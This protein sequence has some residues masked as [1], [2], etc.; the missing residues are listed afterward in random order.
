MA[1]AT[2]CIAPK[3]AQAA[4]D[5]PEKFALLVGISE[6]PETSEFE[7]LSGPKNDV[8][9]VRNMLIETFGFVDD[10]SHVLV[11]QDSAATVEAIKAAF[12][13]HLID[14]AR[15]HPDGS[16]VFYFSGHGIQL[17]DLESDEGDRLD[18][19]LVA[20]DSVLPG[21]S[22]L[23]DDEI[24]SLLRDL[25]ELTSSLGN[26]T[27]IVDSCYSGNISRGNGLRRSRSLP[28]SEDDGAA[29]TSTTPT[30][31]NL[32][33][34]LL[35]YDTK[36]SVLSAALPHEE[37]VEDVIPGEIEGKVYGLFTYYLVR[38]LRQNSDLT[39]DAA[40]RAINLLLAGHTHQHANA[41]GD[42][43]RIVLGQSTNRVTP[44]IRVLEVDG[45]NLTV[46]AGQIHG[47][48]S[49]SLLSIYDSDQ[50]EL[51]GEQGRL[52]L[53]SVIEVSGDDAVAQLLNVPLN[54][55]TTDARAAVLSFNSALSP[56]RVALSPE[57]ELW[58][59]MAELLAENRLAI[60]VDEGEP[61]DLRIEVDCPNLSTTDLCEVGHFL[62][63]PTETQPI[64]GIKIEGETSVVIAAKM[65]DLIDRWAKHQ[66]LLS[67]YNGV[68][69]LNGTVTLQA[70]KFEKLLF[71][72]FVQPGA[73]QPLPA[74]EVPRLQADDLIGFRIQNNSDVRL[75]VTLL[76]LGQDGS[77]CNA[78]GGN[79]TV[80]MV[81]AATLI[82]G[83]RDTEALFTEGPAGTVTYKLIAT[84]NRDVNFRVLESPGINRSEGMLPLEVLLGQ[85]ISYGNGERQVFSE[86]RVDDWTTTELQIL[87]E[88][89]GSSNTSRCG[90]SDPGAD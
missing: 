88:D 19:A 83:A 80:E 50:R 20:Y 23:V 25:T 44:H 48:R 86:I 68:S 13:S 74:G 71:D 15:Q 37:A 76:R 14:N 28:S 82:A 72:G 89:R 62:T 8:V 3:T 52:A 22:F 46:A 49:G 40:W 33:D 51:E 70:L 26:V 57:S 17:R 35:I 32:D 18:E 75:Y 27:V 45:S 60:L 61:A 73:A 31:S 64:F 55:I 90:I 38:V 67:I 81:P 42:V 84:T 4:S 1:V 24:A 78:L 39:Y 65:V 69:P 59:E 29:G 9:L 6:Y 36:Y 63:L 16:F 53:A 77:I 43:D 11:L 34:G 5:A 21:G 47:I 66:N 56:Y 10:E 58:K 79:S 41:E 30:A 7:P 85:A 2:L 87:V 54:R 12:R